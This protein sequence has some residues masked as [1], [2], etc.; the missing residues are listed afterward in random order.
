MNLLFL[1]F[2]AVIKNITLLLTVVALQAS[3]NITDVPDLIIIK[4]QIKET[5][6]KFLFKGNRCAGHK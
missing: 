6:F 5:T 4:T 3:T 2:S 1:R